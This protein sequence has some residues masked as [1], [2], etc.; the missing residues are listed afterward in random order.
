MSTLFC[1]H[2]FTGSPK[3]WGFLDD[4]PTTPRIAPALVGHA[5]SAAGTEV[6]R[7]EDEVDRLAALAADAASLHVVGYSLGARLALGL[8]LRHPSRVARLTLISAHPGLATQSERVQRRASDAT[9]CELLETRGIEAFVDA[10]QAQPLWASQARLPAAVSTQKQ[11]ERLSHTASGLCRS[12]RVTGLAEMPCYLP[13]LSEIQAP[14]DVLAGALDR[15]FCDLAQVI[16]K[17]S[18]RARIEIV[19]EAGH[20]LLLERPDFIT[21][22]IRRGSQA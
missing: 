14:I 9:W 6:L 22:V 18:T 11:Q 3:S 7:F 21:A 16:A 10:W 17:N 19:P 13:A 2:G 20:D 4:L 5:G 15:K 12:L 1:V 8:A